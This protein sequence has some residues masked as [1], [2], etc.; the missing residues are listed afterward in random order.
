MELLGPLIHNWK[1]YKVSESLYF[2]N[3]STGCA[4][5]VEDA[6]DEVLSSTYMVNMVK[7]ELTA[8]R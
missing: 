3:P 2:T 6:H 7:K 4:E 5:D 1:N 8:T